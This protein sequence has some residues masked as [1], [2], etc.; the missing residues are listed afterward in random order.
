MLEPWY[1]TLCELNIAQKACSP[2]LNKNLFV[3]VI[4]NR[5]DVQFVRR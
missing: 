1:E 3:S 2:I 5:N 4:C